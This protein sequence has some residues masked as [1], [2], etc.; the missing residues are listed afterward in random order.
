[1]PQL[2]ETIHSDSRER[3]LLLLCLATFACFLTIGLPLP[4]IPLY[5]HDQL[6]YGAV[7]VGSAV[8]VQFL[9]TVLT[10]GYAGRI[11]DQQG[12]RTAMLR[13]FLGCGLTGA[14]YLLAALLPLT[15]S[16]KLAV[17]ILGRL[18]LGVGESF[19]VTGMLAWGIGA[20]GADKAGKVMSWT[21]LA[22][23][24]AMAV[25]APCGLALYQTSGLES[26]GALT[27][28]LPL[29]SLAL[30]WRIADIAPGP[31]G[32]GSLFALLGRICMP[33]LILALQGVGFA[34]IGAFISLDFAANGWRG[35]GLALS[36]FGLAFALVRVVAG[37]LPDRLG[38]PRV[39]IV[40][41]LVEGLG[42]LLLWSAPN[43]TL[44]LVGAAITGLG[45][46]LIFPALGL[47]VVK[48]VDSRE[49]ATALGGYAA[50]QDIAYGLTG[51]LTGLLAAI[52]GFSSPFLIGALAAFIGLG[53]A[54]RIHR[55]EKA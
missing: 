1:M 4:V 51:P 36:C 7:M 45:S 50:F 12:P 30:V 27:L 9:A 47:V 35:A 54:I 17:L 43:A 16:G 53:L 6:G 20:V 48:R 42:L 40:S 14:F 24:G 10:R 29:L 2:D 52:Y 11:A 55:Q 18:T 23:Y 8:G 31:G 49:R 34:A 26:L 33:G 37:H 13:G 25:G 22:I 28:L 46:S 38:G 44:A 41:L 3:R 19:L 15:A 39:A 5:V 21:G 32:R